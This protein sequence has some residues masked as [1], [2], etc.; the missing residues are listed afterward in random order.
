[1]APCGLP[2][3]LW[4]W[5]QQSSNQDSVPGL[6]GVGTA[7]SS[8]GAGNVP[9]VWFWL[10]LRPSS[11]CSQCWCVSRGPHQRSMGLRKARASKSC[12]RCPEALRRRP[13]HSHS[14]PLW[15]QLMLWGV[16]WG[17]TCE[18]HLNSALIRHVG[19]QPGRFMVECFFSFLYLLLLKYQDW[20][21]GQWMELD[22]RVWGTQSSCPCVSCQIICNLKPSSPPNIPSG[23]ASKRL[24]IW[25][26]T[27][28]KLE[29]NSILSY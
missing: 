12:P 18:L 9:C 24:R 23:K 11:H 21:R 19:P 14:L 20:G 28:D 22:G 15:S 6:P 8:P 26:L 17:G 3:Q 13:A 10:F 25:A 4:A 5:A 16:G 1:M 7:A 27:L 29:F 2:S